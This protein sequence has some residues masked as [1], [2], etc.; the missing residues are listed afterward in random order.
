MK[1]AAAYAATAFAFC[2]I[3]AIWLT[4]IARGFYRDAIGPLLKEDPNY[5]A[6]AVFYLCYSGAIIYF[7]VL[8]ALDAQSLRLAAL[9]GLL[10]GLIAYGAYDL[11]NLATLKGF[12]L[13]MSVVDMSW[14]GGLT[15]ASATA[16]YFGARLAA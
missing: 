13:R 3:D 12:P 11:T 10:L 6:A 16:G 8:P 2:V 15:A 9:N 5:L 4:M 14:G 7:A 1:F